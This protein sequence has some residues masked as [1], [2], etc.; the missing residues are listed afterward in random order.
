MEQT[1]RFKKRDFKN[2]GIFSK[3]LITRSIVLPITLISK[4]IH[5]IIET[6]IQSHYEGKC[7]VEGYIKVD[8]CKLITFS[9]GLVQANNVKFEVVF[10]CMIAC[11]VEG[12]RINC[13]VKNFTFIAILNWFFCL[14]NTSTIIKLYLC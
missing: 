3:S 5:D 9:S 12:M 8:S 11:P 4:N 7:S 2:E 14:S 6:T 1:K 13:L 10:E